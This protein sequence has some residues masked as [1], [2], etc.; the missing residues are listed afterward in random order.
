MGTVKFQ[1]KRQNY[2]ER[3]EMDPVQ[4]MKHARAAVRAHRKQRVRYL[5]NS[6]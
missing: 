4:E 2:L 5:I 1:E 6:K 3:P